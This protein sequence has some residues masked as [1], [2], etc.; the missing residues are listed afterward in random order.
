MR[1]IIHFIRQSAILF[2]LLLII[3]AGLGIFTYLAGTWGIQPDG[4]RV[5]G[6]LRVPP[7]PPLPGTP[8]AAYAPINPALIP[9]L[10][11]GPDAYGDFEMVVVGRDVA[12]IGAYLPQ[13]GNVALSLQTPS[14]TPS[15]TPMPTPTPPPTAVPPPA[16][17]QPRPQAQAPAQNPVQA[18]TA[19]VPPPAQAAAPV[20]V[21]PPSVAE[22]PAAPELAPVLPSATPILILPTIVT[23]APP[24]AFLPGDIVIPG[25]PTSVPIGVE[26]IYRAS[27]G[28]PACAPGGNPVNGVLTQRFH[29]RHG[30]I[31]IGVPS[32]TPVITTHSGTVIY[33][34]WSEVGYGN[35]VVVRNDPFITYYAHNESI[36]VSVNQQVSRGNIL[37]MSGNTGNSSG[38][39]VHYEI[40]INDLPIDPLSFESRGY[41][42]C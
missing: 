20:E 35:L 32:G 31:D 12:A 16:P 4:P 7:V 18:P 36:S 39:H 30:G 3:P 6:T 41:A 37:A 29:G 17:V 28:G 24:P 19:V 13:T 40:R 34:G 22:A 33:A 42:I 27:P 38:P 23:P 14:P 11:L 10:E 5:V 9:I 25:W 8:V 26:L 2:G 21:A 15:I 1:R